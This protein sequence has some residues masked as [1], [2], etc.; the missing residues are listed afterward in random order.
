VGRAATEAE[1]QATIARLSLE[2]N[3]VRGEIK[4][5]ME[6]MGETTLRLL[7]SGELSHPALA[8]LVDETAALEG[9]VADLEKQIEQVRSG[10]SSS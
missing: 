2:A 10:E 1:K 8:G 3:G 4:R 9:R 7:R 6:E 5:K